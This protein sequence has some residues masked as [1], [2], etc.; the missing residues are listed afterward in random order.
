MCQDRDFFVI[1]LGTEGGLIFRWVHTSEKL[2]KISQLLNVFKININSILIMPIFL[3][4]FQYYHHSKL[5]N[6]RKIN[7]ISRK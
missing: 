1:S 7:L 6:S 4:G 2:F 5:C 3:T